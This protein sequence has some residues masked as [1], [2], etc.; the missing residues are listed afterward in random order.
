MFKMNGGK[1][2]ID[3]LRGVKGTAGQT[4]I[5]KD[6]GVHRAAHIPSVSVAS[7]YGKAQVFEVVFYTTLVSPGALNV[8]MNGQVL[9]ANAPIEFAPC[10]KPHFKIG[11]YRPGKGR[12]RSMLLIDDGNLSH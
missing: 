4:W 3:V 9:L 6:Q 1:L 12:Q 11:I 5:S 7:L 2:K 8:S 10:A